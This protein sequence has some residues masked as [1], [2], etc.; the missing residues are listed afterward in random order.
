MLTYGRIC[1]IRTE[2]TNAKRKK[3]NQR[4]VINL[5]N[6]YLIFI[7]TYIYLDIS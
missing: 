7:G 6:N 2:Q 3:K 5:I 4:H 1:R